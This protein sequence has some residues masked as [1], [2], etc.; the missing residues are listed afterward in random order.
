MKNFAI[1][2]FTVYT[3]LIFI[4]R[5]FRESRVSEIPWFSTDVTK[6]NRIWGHYSTMC[7]A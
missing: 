5:I 7:S 2:K 1:P 3:F 4:L 6:D